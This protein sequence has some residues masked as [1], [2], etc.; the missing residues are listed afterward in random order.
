VNYHASI[1]LVLPLFNFNQKEKT[2]NENEMQV[3]TKGENAMLKKMREEARER[4]E[5]LKKQAAERLKKNAE[6]NKANKKKS[7]ES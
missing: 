3:S 7:K 6:W 2:M 1:S 5:G 4:N